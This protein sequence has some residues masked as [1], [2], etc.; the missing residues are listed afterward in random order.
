MPITTIRRRMHEMATTMPLLTAEQFLEHPSSRWAELIDGVI[1]EM[2]PPGGEHG[3]RQARLIRLLGRAE[4]SGTGVVVGELG[5][6]IRR[7]PDAV[8]A[9]DVAFIRKEHIPAS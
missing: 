6:I 1:I 2:S 4:D 7:N 8:R 5:C 9:P 3:Q